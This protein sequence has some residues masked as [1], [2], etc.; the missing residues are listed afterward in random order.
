ML[1]VQFQRSWQA[2]RRLYAS[3]PPE[4]GGRVYIHHNIRY[5]TPHKW[6]ILLQNEH[7]KYQRQIAYGD[8]ENI[9]KPVEKGLEGS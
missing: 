7:R 1:R 5:F 4:I 6:I 9:V 2:V 3:F 8:R